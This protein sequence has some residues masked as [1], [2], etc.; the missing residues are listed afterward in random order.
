MELNAELFRTRGR[1]AKP[2]EA[3]IVRELDSADMV[4]LSTERGVK[5]SAVKRLTDRHHNLA[6]NLAS[7]MPA[8]EAAVLCGYT[9]SRV[10]ILQ[11]DPAFKEL[12]EFY[13]EDANRPYRDLHVRLSGLALDAAEELSNRLEEEP[14]KISIGQLTELTKLGADRTGH[15]P[16]SSTLNVN[17]DLAGRMEAARKRVAMRKLEVIEGGLVEG[18][19]IER[20]EDG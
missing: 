2:V 3:A 6:R 4:L 19:V 8:G 14:E 7:G 17:V 12:L 18:E 9:A 1:A 15:G 20:N 10:S 13:R 5:P 11:N 16:Q